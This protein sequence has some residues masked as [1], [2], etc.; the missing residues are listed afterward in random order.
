M[1]K[2][3]EPLTSTRASLCTLGAI[4]VVLGITLPLH[5]VYPDKLTVY[6]VIA[7]CVAVVSPFALVSFKVYAES[8]G[9]YSE[10]QKKSA[11]VKF[12]LMILSTWYVDFVFVCM[13]M[14]WLLAFFILAGLYLIKMV[15]SFSKVLVT[16]KDSSSHPNFL[17][18]GDFILSFPLLILIIYKIENQ[19]LQTIVIALSA[20]LIS[21]LLTLLGVILTINKSDRDRK[22]EE[23]NKNKPFFY[24]TPYYKGPYYDH[25]SKEPHRKNFGV[26]GKHPQYLGRFY[27]SDKIEFLI[28]SITFNGKTAECTFDKVVSKGELFE[29]IAYVDD[30]EDR[31][32]NYTLNIEDVNRNKIKVSIDLD[33]SNGEPVPTIHKF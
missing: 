16:R 14:N 24:Y 8:T 20:A 23:L 1:K 10:A 11:S 7:I 3:K 21:G 32:D 28:E 2:E 5:F 9:N 33:R 17:T 13:F 15:Y 19:T 25:N 22:E 27:N 6:W 18:V 31:I 26:S 30:K 12:G 29:L 4:V